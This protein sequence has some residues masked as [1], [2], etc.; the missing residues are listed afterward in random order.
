MDARNFEAFIR[1][2]PHAEFPSGSACLCT[3]YREYTDAYTQ[4][5]YGGKLG[6]NDHGI[7]YG[8]EVGGFHANCNGEFGG[9]L[10]AVGC[11]GNFSVASMTELEDICGQ[12]R[13]WGGM[14]FTK[15]VPAGHELCTELG[16]LAL[17]RINTIMAGSDFGGNEW[18][19][20]DD[21]PTCSEPTMLVNA[22]L[23][24]GSS[25][26]KVLQKMV[27]SVLNLVGVATYLM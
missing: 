9:E 27:T 15:S 11:K 14:H 23:S 5:Y 18:F 24:T 1:V 25:A 20:G 16:S 3:T 13:L 7:I 6:D 21:R 2:M 19:A 10:P 4:K 17:D 8:V 22:S 12:S 26:N